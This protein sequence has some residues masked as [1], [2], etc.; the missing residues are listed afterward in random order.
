MRPVGTINANSMG[1]SLINTL[2]IE[3]AQVTNQG[4]MEATNNGILYINGV[5][6]N[7]QGGNITANGAGATVQLVGFTDIQG[8]TLNNNG[9]ALGTLDGADA[10]L[11]G[12][13]ASGAVTIKG[14]YT[15]GLNSATY[16]LGTINNQGNIL[17]NAG[18]FNSELITD[19]AH[20]TLTGGGT[21]TLSTAGGGG[22]AYIYQQASGYTLENVNNTIQGAGIIGNNGLSFLNDAAGTVLANTPGQTLVFQGAGTV[23]NNGTF[24]ADSGSTLRLQTVASFTNF[25]G[26][27]LT[28]GIYNVY[29]TMGSPGTLQIDALGNTGGEIVNNAATILLDGPNSNFFDA[30]GKDALSNFSNNEAAGSFTI[31]DGRNFTGPSDVNFA[32]AGIVDIGATS[33][34]TT[35]G[36]GNYNQSGGSTQVDGALTAGGGQ[37]NIN[38]G[39]LFGNGTIT[40]NVKMAGTIYP[41]DALNTAGKLSITGNYTQAGTGAFNLSLG[42]LGAG[43]QFSL[44]AVT[45]TAN[46][47]GT[48]NIG[49]INGFFPT[50]GDTFTFLTAGGGVSG[51]FSTVNGLNIGGGEEL[52]VVYNPFNVEI[53]TI[54]VGTTTDSWLGGADVWS[55]AVKWS[56]FGHRARSQQRCR[57]L[58][59][60]LRHL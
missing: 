5:A 13:T 1:G 29:G 16:L 54:M 8:G 44:L 33:T 42:G 49:L 20:V 48:L 57:H 11:D 6:V 45:G 53:E 32:N 17:V 40:G 9:G 41:G 4:L 21:V 52:M 19:A 35:G 55:N 24:Q 47:N 31:R 38:G 58:L 43:T 12:S 22:L 15:N 51:M 26:N 28:G 27:T 3:S 2:T 37:V 59:R 56:S 50:T 18:T 34:F 14:N 10:I 7:N 39:T 46:L 60:R 25:S 36:T 23:T 30:A